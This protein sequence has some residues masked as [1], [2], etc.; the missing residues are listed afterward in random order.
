MC[1]QR[2][3]Y[4]NRYVPSPRAYEEAKSM[5]AGVLAH[6]MK[7]HKIN[8]GK[9]QSEEHISKRINKNE[10]FIR[11]DEYKLKISKANSKR[12]KDTRTNIVYESVSLAAAALNCSPSNISYHLKK[13]LYKVV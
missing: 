4:Q 10:K 8:L 5:H 1:N 11:S 7:G 6:S 9:K 2:R 3:N 12:I 13:G